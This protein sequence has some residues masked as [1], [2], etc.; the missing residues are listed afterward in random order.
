MAIRHTTV[1]CIL[2]TAFS[3]MRPNRN[4][5]RREYPLY[6]A[7][8]SYVYRSEA[9]VSWI[10]PWCCMRSMAGQQFELY[11]ARRRF[12]RYGHLFGHRRR[13]L[14]PE[15]AETRRRH[16]EVVRMF[17]DMKKNIKDW[18]DEDEIR[19]YLHAL[20]NKQAFDKSGLIYGMGHA[21]YSISDPRA[22]V[23][24]KF[25]KKAF[26]RKGTLRRIRPVFPCGTSRADR[27]WRRA[28]NL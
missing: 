27:N 10:L 11:N 16:V 15:R 14:A 12:F 13:P 19:S 26:G 5:H 22:N 24:K 18:T 17:E 8:G 21:V 3:S 25:V 9:Q 2:L 4:S 23:F 6:A 20:L 28:Q 7:S 1:S